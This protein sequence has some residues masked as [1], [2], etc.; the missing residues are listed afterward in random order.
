M[1]A[2]LTA[3]ESQE[4]NVYIQHRHN[5]DRAWIGLNDIATEGLFTWVDG[6]P[7]RFRYWALNQP[8]DF[9]GEDC[10]H[11]LGVAHGYMWND[12]DC[13]T[14]HQYTCKKGELIL[15]SLF[16]SVHW[17]ERP[18]A[19]SG[20]LNLSFPCQIAIRSILISSRPPV[21]RTALLVRRELWSTSKTLFLAAM[22]IQSELLSTRAL[23]WLIDR[24]CT[25]YR[26]R[27]AV[28]V[29]FV[30]TL[31]YDECSSSPCLNGGT[32][33]NGK[34][35]FSCTCPPTHKGKTCEGQLKYANH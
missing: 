31:D 12:V 29:C 14:C 20:E 6:C 30:V 2:S 35:T 22:D 19:V 5:G 16:I 25:S 13:S 34:R 7:F 28:H 23:I 21:E 3:V 24:Y 18:H 26:Q 27:N 15:W 32:C 9:R 17:H 1:G 4:E 8:N 11:T 33:V 10:V